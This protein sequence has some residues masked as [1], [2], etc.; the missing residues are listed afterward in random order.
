MGK[1]S[2]EAIY[3]IMWKVSVASWKMISSVFAWQID[4]DFLSLCFVM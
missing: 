4:F 1:F 2:L 3:E